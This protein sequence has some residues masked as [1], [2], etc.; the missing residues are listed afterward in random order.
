MT[1]KDRAGA[2]VSAGPPL[3]LL[4]REKHR[5]YVRPFPWQSGAPVPEPSAQLPEARTD[6]VYSPC[7]SRFAEIEGED[8]AVVLRNASD[9]T[10]VRR[11]GGLE[12]IICPLKVN[13]VTWS[14]KGTFLLT[15]SRPTQGFE[16]A[17]LIIW[18]ADSGKRIAGWFQKVFHIKYWPTVQWSDDE[19]IAARMVT[20]TI[21]YY[22]GHDIKSDTAPISKLRIEGVDKF[23]LSKGAAP[24]TIAAFVPGK[25]GGGP[26]RIAIYEHPNEGGKLI[27]Q[28][29]T[30]R[31]D[32]VTFLWNSRGSSVLALTSTNIDATGKS[33]YGESEMHFFKADGSL[34]QR[35]ELPKDGPT[36]D[37]AWSPTGTEFVVVYGFMPARATMFNEKCEP[38]FDFGSGSGRNTISFSPHGRFV[39]LAGFG[40]LSGDVEFWDKSKT[41]KLGECQL[42]CTT[43]FCWSPCSRYFLGATTFPRLRVDNQF[44]V[45]R[46]DGTKILEHRI[47]KGSHLHQATFQPALRGVYEDPKLLVSAGHFLGGPLKTSIVGPQ[48]GKAAKNEPKMGV[49]R[50]PGMRGRAPAFSLH[51]HVAAGKV[52]KGSFMRSAGS[53]TNGSLNGRKKYIPGMDPEDYSANKPSKSAKKK[54]K[55]KQK[56]SKDAGGT[57]DGGAS[58]T[59]PKPIAELTT[60]EMVAKRMKAANKKLKQIETLKKGKD[61][62]KVLDDDQISKIGR[63]G[64]WKDELKRLEARLKQLST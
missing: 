33:Y 20:N 16:G 64:H 53:G 51:S 37:A 17:N 57:T 47:E 3:S 50:P 12:S 41:I 22:D 55:K 46:F 34:D 60:T 54:A 5:S 31:A 62:G 10:E 24:Y 26:A 63:E 44:T 15:W 56:D 58:T 9:G 61:E 7:G 29:S 23:A 35:V 13:M 43:S 52:D 36:Y 40:N 38:T 14:P 2:S 25:K 8:A 19:S 30:F 28:R 6:A 49:Y 32:S 4:I 45:V 59:D 11:F 27:A 39:A 42:P 21:H 48:A 18:N 1:E